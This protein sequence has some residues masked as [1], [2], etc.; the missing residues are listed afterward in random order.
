MEFLC[1]LLFPKQRVL[2]VPKKIHPQRGKAL[3]LPSGKQTNEK[4]KGIF[5]YSRHMQGHYIQK[6]W[7]HYV[8]FIVSV[9][10]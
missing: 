3:N 7:S 1:T 10:I 2:R 9:K 6:T 8:I 4:T 5:F